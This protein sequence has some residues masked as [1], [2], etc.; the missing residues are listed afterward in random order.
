MIFIQGI[1]KWRYEYEWPLAATEWTKYYLREKGILSE[2]SPGSDEEPQFFTS[3]P[4]ANP[5]QGYQRADTHAPADPIPKA[6][7]ETERLE[8]DTELTGPIALYWHASI[9]SEGIQ[10]RTWESPRTQILYPL[11]N[12]TGWYLK[13]FDVADDGYNRCVAEGWLKAYHY[14]IDQE[15]TKPYSPQ[16]PHIRS[17]PI[18]PGQVI[19]YASD[20]RMT[21][22]VFKAGHRIRLEIAAQDRVQALW[23]HPPHMARVKHVIYSTGNRPSYLLLPIIPKGYDG[24]GEAHYPPEGPFRIMK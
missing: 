4:W 12:D 14:E 21:S 3:D 1:N 8:E 7:Y 17:L 19:P 24:G 6:I 13:L 22:N 5:T 18:E 9:E 23:Y 10:A 11:T 15:K 16:H 2:S 20:P